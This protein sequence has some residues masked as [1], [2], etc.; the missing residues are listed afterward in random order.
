MIRIARRFTFALL[1]LTTSTNA[2]AQDGYQTPPKVV[3]DILDAPAFPQVQISSDRSRMLI[4]ER[5]NMPAIADL[6]QP[7]LRLAGSRCD[8]IFPR[9]TGATFEAVDGNK[10]L[11]DAVENSPSGKV[12][13][14][15]AR[16]GAAWQMPQVGYVPCH[17]STPAKARG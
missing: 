6:A 9:G 16:R 12:V 5:A 15:I 4:I 1:F 13:V 14:Q 3:M 8:D 11:R 10:P 2:F 17:D 7:M